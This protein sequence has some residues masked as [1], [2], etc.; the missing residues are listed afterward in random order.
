MRNGASTWECAVFHG[1]KLFGKPDLVVEEIAGI[2]VHNVDGRAQPVIPGGQFETLA[3]LPLET[4]GFTA[5]ALIGVTVR[6]IM[7]FTVQ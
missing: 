3:I 2:L 4:V 5:S 1:R 7:S 6:S